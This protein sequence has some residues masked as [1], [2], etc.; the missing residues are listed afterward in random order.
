MYIYIYIYYVDVEAK[1]CNASRALLSSAGS[2]SSWAPSQ[3][4]PPPEIYVCMYIYIYI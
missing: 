4:A 1:V 3:A 2:R